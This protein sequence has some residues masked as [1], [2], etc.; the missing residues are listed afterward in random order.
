MQKISYYFLDVA[1]L[2]QNDTH[3]Y[4]ISC[5][6]DGTFTTFE[7]K[8]ELMVN[9]KGNVAIEFFSRGKH[10][11]I[12][13]TESDYWLEKIKGEFFLI[14]TSELRH[15]I[16]QKEY[17]DIKSGGDRG[18]NTHFYLVKEAKFKSWCK[19]M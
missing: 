17:D 11:G 7:V 6:I 4:D 13:V 9:K 10:T 1:D 3:A 5:N 15:K 18:S 16:E 8:N 14:K 19:K 2:K 12:D